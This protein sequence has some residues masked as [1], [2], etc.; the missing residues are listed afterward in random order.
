MQKY[1]VWP[2]ATS[3]VWRMQ[4]PN[5]HSASTIGLPSAD[6]AV[7]TTTI[8]E[9]CTM[10]SRLFGTEKA[11]QQCWIHVDITMNNLHFY[12]TKCGGA[13]KNFHTYSCSFDL[14]APKKRFS[15][16]NRNISGI[17]VML[18]MLSMKGDNF[19]GSPKVSSYTCLAIGTCMLGIGTLHL[20][21]SFMPTP[22][23][24]CQGCCSC[25]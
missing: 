15:S 25:C 8:A 22:H 19:A 12:S 13:I 9:D 24:P 4:S 7:L 11:P 17:K 20:Q 18:Q 16:E 21:C 10:L 2:V 6:S 5:S 23:N 3:D 1:F 14:A